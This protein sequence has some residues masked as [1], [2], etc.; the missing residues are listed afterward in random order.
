MSTASANEDQNVKEDYVEALC[1][2]VKPLTL[3][4]VLQKTQSVIG[5]ACG[6]TGGFDY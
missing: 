4:H 2:D 3:D 1:S 6:L 5:E